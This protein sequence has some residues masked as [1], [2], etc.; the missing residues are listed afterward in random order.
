MVFIAQTERFECFYDFLLIVYTVEIFVST[1]LML[2]VPG[3]VV[4]CQEDGSH[5]VFSDCTS[6]M[7]MFMSHTIATM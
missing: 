5:W 7:L 3:G 1:L 4:G 6:L 2:V